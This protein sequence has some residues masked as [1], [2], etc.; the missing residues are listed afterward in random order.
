MT[1]KQTFYLVKDRVRDNAIQAVKDA[2]YGSVISVS[3]PKRSL[4]Q[5][6]KFH[7][8]LTDIAR[9]PMEWAGKRRTIEEWKALTISA[10]A[11]ATNQAGEIIPGIEGEF[12][13]IRESTAQMGVA[14]ASSLIEYVIAFCVQHGIEMREA[15]KQG[16]IPDEIQSS[17]AASASDEGGESVVRRDST[18]P[19]DPGG[20][21]PPP[22]R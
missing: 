20:E 15:K 9:S 18:P 22:F 21:P 11:V 5:N 8:L 13:A 2:E 19:D 1:E 14:R 4:E 7:A 3:P 12:V 16:Y 17:E 6:G 10:H